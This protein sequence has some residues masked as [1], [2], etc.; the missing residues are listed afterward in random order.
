MAN[1]ETSVPLPVAEA[2]QRLSSKSTVIATLAMDR[3]TSTILASSGQTSVFKV[4]TNGNTIPSRLPS[5]GKSSNSNDEFATMIWN[6]VNNTSKLV[7][8]MD[9]EDG[10]RLLRIRTKRYELVIIP[11]SK[12][13]FVVAHEVPY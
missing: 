2:M 1:S 7:L 13:I 12:Y 8:E 5:D 6:Y 3:A 9:D 10:L 11:D 4:N